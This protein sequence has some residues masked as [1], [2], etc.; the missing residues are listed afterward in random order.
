MQR[1]ITAI[2]C[3]SL[4]SPMVWA[5]HGTPASTSTSIKAF[6][7]ATYPAPQLLP[8]EDK[9]LSNL[10]QLT[11][12]GEN[13][14]A[15]WSPDGKEII[16]QSTQPPFSCD[17]VF[18]MPADGSAEPKLVSTGKGRCTCSYFIPKSDRL[19]YASTHEASADCPT[20]PPRGKEYTWMLY[21]GYDIFSANRDGSDPV[22]LTKQTG[23]DAE[24]IVSENGQVVIF[25]SLRDGDVDIY[26]MNLDGSNVQRLTDRKGYDGGPWWSP[27]GRKIVWRAEYPQ[28]AADSARWDSLLVQNIVRP[29]K[30]E[31]WIMNADG[32]EKR[33]LTNL[34][35]STFAPVWMR[36]NR[37]ILFVSN[38]DDPS[39]RNFELYQIDTKNPDKTERITIFDG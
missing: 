24:A 13:A 5:Q 23:Y 16:F 1:I 14:E 27:N 26:R 20:P 29:R 38:L 15:Y 12:G 33:Q 30:L 3:F 39:G 4:L 22:N 7:K 19:L 17:Q 32:S 10:R 9:H 35:G 37:H 11:F 6:E 18:T 36:D 31:L 2:I 21:P 28:N 8:G 25:T 34:S